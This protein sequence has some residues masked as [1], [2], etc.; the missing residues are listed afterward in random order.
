[1]KYQGKEIKPTNILRR[2]WN[3]YV[4]RNIILA[5]SILVIILFLVSMLLNVFTRHNSHKEVPDFTSINIV[6]AKKMARKN[7]LRIEINDSLYVT[8]FE[9]GAIL[10]QKP[11]AGTKV[12]PGRR[13]YVTINSSQQKMADVPYVTGYS[14]RQAKNILETAGFEI[15]ELIY[16]NDI[17]TNNVLEERYHSD[18]IRPGRKTQAPVGSG[19]TLTVGKSSG[20]A[21]VAIPRVVGLP[22]RNAKGRLWESGLNVGK[23]D[24]DGNIDP[25]ELRNARV[26]RQI[27]EQGLRG[28]LGTEVTL[29][30]STDTTKVASGIKRS[31]SHGT[32]RA[33][34][35]RKLAD[36]LTKAGFPENQILEEVEWIIKIENGEATQEDRMRFTEDEILRSLQDYGTS[37][38]E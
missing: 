14:L 28:T 29:Y 3:N 21:S 23:V 32:K 38:E 26:Y 34:R 37:D 35:E 36:S 19:I 30:I 27:P 25:R 16:V 12:K 1:M 2:M 9:P 8:S 10:E 20:A 5:G 15:A 22:I 17:A 24:I 7:R 31:D 33:A 4:V 6:D 13:I 18:I 11:T